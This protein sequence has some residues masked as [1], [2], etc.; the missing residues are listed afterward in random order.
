MRMVFEKQALSDRVTYYY[1]PSRGSRFDRRREAGHSYSWWPLTP[2]WFL[3]NAGLLRNGGTPRGH[4]ALASPS[5]G[6]SLLCSLQLAWPLQHPPPPPPL[7]QACRHWPDEM[8]DA[9]NRAC[10]IEMTGG[11]PLLDTVL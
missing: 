8:L 9:S 7:H 11:R 2:S 10:T 3:T 4:K 1:L 6:A 5:T